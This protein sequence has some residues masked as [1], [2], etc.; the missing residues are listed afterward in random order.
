[1]GFRFLISKVEKII[2]PISHELTE[3]N[4]AK[5]FLSSLMEMLFKDTN[6][7]FILWRRLGRQE[8]HVV[9]LLPAHLL[10]CSSLPTL[11]M[12]FSLASGPLHQLVLSP[13]VLLP[14]ISTLLAPLHYLGLHA[15]SYLKQHP[16]HVRQNQIPLPLLIFLQAPTA[17][18][19]VQSGFKTIALMIST[20]KVLSQKGLQKLDFR[21]TAPSLWEIPRLFGN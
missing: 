7:I 12:K 11:N 20:E 21:I 6:F 19:N 15:L 8:S 9:W 4:D 1:M 16:P 10:Y 14:W 17:L 13:R 5:A 3:V 18:A 2:I